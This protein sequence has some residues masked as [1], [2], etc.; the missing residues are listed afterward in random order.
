LIVAIDFV[1][2]ELSSTTMPTVGVKRRVNDQLI[3]SS[4]TSPPPSRV[5]QARE[6]R[7]D[8]FIRDRGIIEGECSREITVAR[9]AMRVGSLR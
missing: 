3:L 2:G 9:N 1:P 7:Q 6:V 5:N 8:R 4:V